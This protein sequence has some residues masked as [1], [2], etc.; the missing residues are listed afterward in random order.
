MTLTIAKKTILMNWKSR[1]TINMALWK[2][3]LIDYISVEKLSTSSNNSA[4]EPHSIW[5]SLMDFLQT[6][7]L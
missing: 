6:R 5:S 3:L 4:T 1:S 2:N 7:F